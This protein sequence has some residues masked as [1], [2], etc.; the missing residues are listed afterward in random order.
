MIPVLNE[1]SITAAVMGNHDFDFGVKV[2]QKYAKKCNF[3]WLLS[4]VLDSSTGRQLA[5]ALRYIVIEHQ[6]IKIGIMGLAEEE[7]Y[8][9][10]LLSHFLLCALPILI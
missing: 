9:S 7:W 6:G 2:L 3:P 1:L 8:G 10:R 4:N 5:D